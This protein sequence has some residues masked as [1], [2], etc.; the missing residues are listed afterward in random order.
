MRPPGESMKL[1]T[2]ATSRK[3]LVTV[4]TVAIF[5]VVIDLLITSQILSALTL[6]DSLCLS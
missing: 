3:I 2:I 1:N 5:L 4:G 6:W